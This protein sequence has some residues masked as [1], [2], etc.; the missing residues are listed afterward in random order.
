M[1]NM[2]IH[3]NLLKDILFF[4]NIDSVSYFKTKLDKFSGSNSYYYNGIERF[5]SF[6]I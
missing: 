2:Y 3:A 6:F 4:M 1:E 5:V